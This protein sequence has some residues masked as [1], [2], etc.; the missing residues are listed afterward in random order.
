MLNKLL[1]FLLMG[2]LA[3]TVVGCD[4]DDDN[5]DTDD[6]SP[7]AQVRFF[8]AAPT[9]GSV[10]VALEGN[11][12][13]SDFPYRG[14]VDNPSVS[15]YFPVPI[16][17]GAL[18][19]TTSGGTE[20]VNVNVSSLNL[21]ADARYTVVVAGTPPNVQPILL[22]DRFSTSLDGAASEIGLRLVHAASTVPG[23]TNVD[24]Y[25]VP[26]NVP[27]NNGVPDTVPA[28][29]E[30]FAFGGDFP[31]AP[32]SGAFVAQAIS[33]PPARVVVT[34]ADDRGTVA[35]EV[36]AGNLGLAADGTEFVTAVA[37]DP[38]TSGGNF[39]ALTLIESAP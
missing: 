1:S 10:D 32:F 17:A 37:I 38:A 13:A 25:L 21:E 11:A 33:S 2:L 29:T 8:H 9:A 15:D 30:D 12:V 26:A 4:D 34:P 28:V 5:G 3:L 27:L 14:V 36:D 23:G 18:T 20:V 6:T 35:I 39:G 16:D 24:V 31:G 7:T 19:V 22:E